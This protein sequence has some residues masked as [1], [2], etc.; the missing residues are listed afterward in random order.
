MAYAKRVARRKYRL[1]RRLNAALSTRRIFS[2]RGARSQ[3]VQI[4]ALRKRINHVYRMTKPETKI[5]LSDNKISQF[6]SSSLSSVWAYMSM[7]V[8]NNGNTDQDRLGNLINMKTLTYFLSGEYFN[9]SPSGYHDTESSGAQVRFVVLQ[10]KD[11]TSTTNVP[12]L[13][14]IL[15]GG[16]TTG[17]GYTLLAVRPLTTNI[18]QKMKVL[19]DKSWPVTLEKNQFFRRVTVHP[20]KI[21]YES[22]GSCN[23]VRAFMIVTG[24]HADTDFTEHVHAAWQCKA[25]YTDA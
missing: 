20:G 1:R 17:A 13:S 14:E 6:S 8:I 12:Q 23:Y 24:L 7:P 22:D 21:R 5:K 11:A 2:N 9:N 25:A 10:Y 15:D 16:S 19:Y 3:A 4:N 18:T